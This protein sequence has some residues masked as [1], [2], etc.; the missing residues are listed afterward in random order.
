MRLASVRLH[1]VGVFEDTTVHFADDAADTR[2]PRA[3][4]VLYGGDG[5][6]KTTL[7]TALAVT[8]PGCALPPAPLPRTAG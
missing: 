2:T 5:I 1:H 4:T 3:A 8:R 6:G 7:L